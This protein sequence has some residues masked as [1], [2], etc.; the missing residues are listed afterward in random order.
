VFCKPWGVAALHLLRF[1]S[2]AI[3]SLCF[4]KAVP[5]KMRQ[6][7]LFAHLFRSFSGPPPPLFIFPA[8]RFLQDRRHGTSFF[9]PAPVFFSWIE[10][11]LQELRRFLFR[12]VFFQWLFVKTNL[13]RPCTSFRASCI[14]PTLII[15]FRM[16][17]LLEAPF[18]L[19]PGVLQGPVKLPFQD[20]HRD[21][22][23][24]L[25]LTVAP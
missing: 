24:L 20:T 13:P 9:P 17:E 7:F 3:F 14:C 4:Q 10:N 1:P 15:F 6:A 21:S 19:P 11:D 2:G 12:L 18:P 8:R 16:F 22:T 23:S 5:E 25:A